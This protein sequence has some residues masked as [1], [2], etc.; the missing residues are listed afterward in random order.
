VNHLLLASHHPVSTEACVSIAKLTVISA[1]PQE[2]GIQPGEE[3][4]QDGGKLKQVE[5]L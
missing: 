4:F 1:P 5:E 3:S 2:W